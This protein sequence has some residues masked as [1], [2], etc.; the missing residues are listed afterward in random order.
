MCVGWVCGGGEKEVIVDTFFSLYHLIHIDNYIPGRGRIWTWRRR[1]G[2]IRS[3]RTLLVVDFF[4][5]RRSL[6]TAAFIHVT[7]KD[8]TK[9]LFLTSRLLWHGMEPYF[10]STTCHLQS[11]MDL[12]GCSHAQAKWWSHRG[13]L[14]LPVPAIYHFYMHDNDHSLTSSHH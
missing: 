14:I 2:A 5:L 4:L 9:N 3:A 8:K 7:G 6:S 10:Y 12:D 11:T 13:A 1:I